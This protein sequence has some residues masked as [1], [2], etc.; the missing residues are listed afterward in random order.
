MSHHAHLLADIRK[1]TRAARKAQPFDS[2]SKADLW[3]RLQAAERA[4]SAS[5][6]A[7]QTAATRAHDYMQGAIGEPRRQFREL[8]DA[9]Q[10]VRDIAR[11]ERL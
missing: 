8:R 7:A 5:A 11:G 6:N 1:A 4:L 9:A 3:N 2:V 10:K